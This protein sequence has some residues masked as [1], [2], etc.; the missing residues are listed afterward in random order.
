MNIVSREK[1]PHIFASIASS[2]KE[3]QKFESVVLKLSNSKYFW[4]RRYLVLKDGNLAYYRKELKIPKEQKKAGMGYENYKATVP[5]RDCE[6]RRLDPSNLRRKNQPFVFEVSF[7]IQKQNKLRRK[8]WVFSVG[9]E[10]LLSEWI[11]QLERAKEDT[12]PEE[13]QEIPEEAKIPEEDPEEVQRREEE[14]FQRLMELEK[15]RNRQREKEIEEQKKKEQIEK[16]MKRLQEEAE[17]KKKQEEETRKRE[18]YK[19]LVEN[20]WDYRFQKLWSQTLAYKDNFEE[21]LNYG[22]RLFKHVGYFREK[23]ISSSKMIIDELGLPKSK[24]KFQA[25]QEVSAP[26]YVYQNMIFRLTWSTESNFKL[27]GHEFRASDMVFDALY[28]LGRKEEDFNFRLPLTCVVDYKGFR[29]LVM[30][31]APLDEQKSLVHG[32]DSEGVYLTSTEVYENL[33]FVSQVLNLKEHLFHWGEEKP[34][35]YVHLSVFTQLHKSDGYKELESYVKE[36]VGDMPEKESCEDHIYLAKVSDLLPVDLEVSSNKTDLSMKLRPEFFCNLE[37][38]LSADAFINMN[39]Q[40]TYI[41]DLEVVEASRYLQSFQVPQLVELLDSL[42]ILPVDSRSLTEAFHSNGVN[43]RYMGKVAELSNLPHIKEICYVEMVARTCKHLLSTQLT[44]ILFDSNSET[45]PRYETIDTNRDIQKA[46][47][48]EKK[49][50]EVSEADED[51]LNY[52]STPFRKRAFTKMISKKLQ[53]P[54]EE[55]VENLHQIDPVTVKANEELEKAQKEAVVDFLNLVFGVGQETDTFW[56]QILLPKAKE[57]FS[58]TCLERSKVNLH[59]L[60]FAVVFHCSLQLNFYTEVKLAKTESPFYIENLEK[61]CEK[62]KTFNMKNVEYMFLAEKYSDYK[63]EKKHSLAMEASSLKLRVS[64]ALNSDPD[65]Y[66]EP[67]LLS[68]IAQML[69]DSKDYDNSISRV[70]EALIQIH[71]LHAQSVKSWCVLMKALMGKGMT[72]EAL[73]CFDNALNAIEFHWGPYHPL[74]S[75]VYTTLGSLYSEQENYEDSL[76]LY[77][78][79]LMCCLKVLGPNH[80]H[81]AEVYVELGDLYTRIDS[82]QDALNSMQKAYSIYESSLGEDSL[83]AVTT[84]AQLSHLLVIGGK[85]ERALPLISN[86]IKTH[87]SIIKEL[88]QEQDP[89]NNFKVAQH[90]DKLCEALALGLTISKNTLNHQ[91]M[92]KYSDKMWVILSIRNTQE[93]SELVEKVLSMVMEAKLALMEPEKKQKVVSILMDPEL[94]N[95][96]EDEELVAASERIKHPSW[97]VKTQ[98]EAGLSKYIHKLFNQMLKLS[99][100]LQRNQDSFRNCLTEIQGIFEIVGVEV[101]EF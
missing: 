99:A 39:E 95:W 34:P 17:K 63:Q 68:D 101:L 57:H 69:I 11:D 89:A 49:L 43:V 55:T 97:V 30:A 51:L 59:A 91:L 40:E 84:G 88:E 98:Q 78:N 33:S 23:A 75:T 6:I 26:F 24:R 93:D 48:T 13:Y 38:Q 41:D 37:T 35:A 50:P 52:H 5:I 2:F 87:E 18:N 28:L 94:Q 79:A 64:K 31:L 56:N 73:Q 10:K 53:M 1:A 22:I 70:K 29:M 82:F 74:H 77:K 21:N 12:N 20:S 47:S 45:R 32:P 42:T 96:I 54:N 71:P 72:E 7:N 4:N 92:L 65:F 60:L 81:T 25:L 27:F 14:E 90:Y 67:S 86:C 85:Y 19:K 61:I 16:E 44:Q 58:S 76:M 80:P 83:M 15:R 46:K 66:G 8:A 36:Y 9:S 100:Q 62:T 3:D